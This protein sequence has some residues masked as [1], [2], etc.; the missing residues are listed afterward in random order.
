MDEAIAT[1]YKLAAPAA[2]VT[3]GGLMAY[4]V[5]DRRDALRT[6]LAVQTHPALPPRARLLS[7]RAAAP[8]AQAMMPLDHGPGHTPGGVEAYFVICPSPPGPA[9]SADPRPWPES[10]IIRCLLLPAAAALDALAERGV[11]HRAINPANIFR[12]GPG[13]KIVL[14]PCWAAPPASLQPGAYEPPYS[15]QCLPTGRGEGSPHDDIYALGVT[16]L[17]C[18]LGGPADPAIA[19]W[20]DEEALLRRKL[21]LGSLAAL[22]GK[23]RLSSTLAE[24]L[25]GMLAED[26]DHRPSA[27]LLLDPEQA[28]GRRVATRQ[29]MRAQSVL[30]VGGEHA[31]FSRELAHLMVRATDDGATLLRAGTVGNWLRRSVGDTQLAVRLEESLAR[32]STEPPLEGAKPAHI[33]VARATA[34]L[35]PLAPVVWRGVAVFPDGIAS[36]LAYASLSNQPSVVATLQEMLDQDVT[37]AW[38]AGRVPRAELTRMQQEVRDWRAWLM[39]KGLAGGLA[40]V[41]YG[42]NVL[43]ACASPALGGRIVARLTDLLPALDDAALKADRKRPPMDAHIA[44]FIAAHADASVLADADRLG[45]LHTPDDRLLAIAL[46]G[47]LQQRINAER[48]PHLAA[49]LIESGLGELGQWR[50]V[51]TRK[52]LEAKLSDLAAAGQILPMAALLGDAPAR[53]RDEAGA[54][55]AARRLADIEMALTS[56]G[57]GSE[58]RL[59]HARQTG[60][61]IATGLSLISLLMGAIWVALAG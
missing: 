7:G 15:A 1:H 52:A 49:W 39:A 53:A 42:G 45:G 57:H 40:R 60:H 51:A 37:T 56:F 17:W 21:C 14:G 35:D 3:V 46:L 4:P 6:L 44:A 54:E 13:E 12:A 28:R 59:R 50:S 26:P 8:V 38:L 61:E 10:E 22:A 16:M 19:A 41:L 34:A 32:L 18:M 33:I 47:R 30:A 2:P 25:R 43:L 27:T 20:A 5:T 55:A 29:A 58:H 24:L 11:T 9:I 36:A 23:A 31:A 48:T